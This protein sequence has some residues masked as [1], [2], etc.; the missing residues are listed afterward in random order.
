MDC[1]LEP[2][3]YIYKETKVLFAHFSSFFVKKI[4]EHLKRHF[5]LVNEAKLENIL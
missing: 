1:F 4:S 5:Y 2:Q 3:I